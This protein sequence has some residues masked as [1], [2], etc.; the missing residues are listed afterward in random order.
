MQ[1]SG[2]E[3]AAV[4]IVG[5]NQADNRIWVRVRICYSVT[6]AHADRHRGWRRG[7]GQD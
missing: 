5:R 3:Q 4:G 7:Y 6:P 2:R 1:I